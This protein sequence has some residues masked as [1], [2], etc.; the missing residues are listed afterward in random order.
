VLG[1][2][3]LA[4]LAL[5]TMPLTLIAGIV[6]SSAVLIAVAITDTVGEGVQAPGGST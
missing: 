5:A 4:L 6:A 2:A 1:L 3:T